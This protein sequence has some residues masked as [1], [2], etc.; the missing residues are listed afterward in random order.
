MEDSRCF[1]S[2]KQINCWLQLE[3][4]HT[5][6]RAKQLKC[7]N[8]CG[9]WHKMSLNNNFKSPIISSQCV[10]CQLLSEIIWSFFTASHHQRHHMSKSHYSSGSN[11]RVTRPWEISGEKN[12]R[13]MTL[14]Y[15]GRNNTD[16]WSAWLLWGIILTFRTRGKLLQT[17]SHYSKSV[18]GGIIW[19]SQVV[20]FLKLGENVSLRQYIV[21]NIKAWLDCR[22]QTT[23]T[24]REIV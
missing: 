8:N 14:K 23:S 22:I 4:C 6:I 19:E 24:C 17:V 18:C 9:K 20:N 7:N 12:G 5:I 21:V 11:L 13:K 2:F 16:V 10:R 15:G 1:S 3:L